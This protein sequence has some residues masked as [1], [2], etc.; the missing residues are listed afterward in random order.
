[1]DQM[2]PF[3]TAT[4]I[5]SGDRLGGTTALAN[6]TIE[7]ALAPPAETGGAGGANNPEELFALGYAACFHSALKVAGSRQG[8][9]V[10][11]ST[12]TAKVMIGNADGVH[13]SGH[14]DDT[15]SLGVELI[16]TVP[17]LTA[18]EVQELLEAAHE[19]CVYSK[20]TRGNIPVKLSVG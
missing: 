1:M 6:G 4:A 3:Y 13:K 20:A 10:K 11:N 16:A 2:K 15:F 9:S 19:L 14:R 17:E 18:D 12:I 5:A 8:K 7:V